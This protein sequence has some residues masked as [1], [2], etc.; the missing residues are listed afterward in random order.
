MPTRSDRTTSRPRPARAR[1]RAFLERLVFRAR[2]VRTRLAGLHALARAAG[3]SYETMRAAVS[4]C[5]KQG[6]V[7]AIA[8]SGVF[9]VGRDEGLAAEARPPKAEA[10]RERILNDIRQGRF[11]PGTAL[12]QLKRLQHTYGVSY[13]PLRGAL[14]DLVD[15]GELERTGRGY[16]V[17]PRAHQGFSSSIV[18]I[19]RGGR[20]GEVRFPGPRTQQNLWFLEH[21]C[22]A[23]GITLHVVPYRPVARRFAFPSG[24]TTVLDSSS[25]TPVLGY[26]IWTT[27]LSPASLIPVLRRLAPL[28]RPVAVL[29]EGHQLSSRDLPNAMFRL[30][31]LPLGHGA[32]TQVGRFLHNLGHRRVAFF[33]RS[34]APSYAQARLEGLRQA[35]AHT[36]LSPTVEECPLSVGQ[37]LQSQDVRAEDLAAP[38]A[39]SNLPRWTREMLL[40]LLR[41]NVDAVPKM[42]VQS[43]LAEALQQ[44]LEEALCNAPCTAWVCENDRLALAALRFL[45]DRKVQVPSRI[46][47][48][49]F[50]NSADA[51]LHG[52]TSYDFGDHAYI[53]A[54]VEWVLAPA[55][56]A[57]GAHREPPRAFE[58]AIVP[59]RTTA[60]VLQS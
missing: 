34:P 13:R 50:D 48:I 21:E 56:G 33:T 25:A 19:V 32:G 45:K 5:V 14:L 30:Y 55:T 12:P 54:M 46:S 42:I 24:D 40:L 26:L 43:D 53:R 57:P 2:G 10:I 52:L 4:D 39:R 8:G 20:T 18:L 29:N 11:E 16:R 15:K 49:G 9:V 3:V 17:R 38:L 7:E 37:R 23:R 27:A 44:S 47:L 36:D 41:G 22:A 51:A 60:K 35:L 1:A 58:G 28:G 31:D 59:R 6:V